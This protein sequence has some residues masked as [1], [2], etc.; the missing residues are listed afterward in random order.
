MKKDIATRDRWW[1]CSFI[2][3]WTFKYYKK[4]KWDSAEQTIISLGGFESLLWLSFFSLFDW[5]VSFFLRSTYGPLGGCG[6]LLIFFVGGT[7]G[8]RF[9]PWAQVVVVRQFFN[10]FTDSVTVFLLFVILCAGSRSFPPVPCDGQSFG[11]EAVLAL[12]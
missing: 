11:A 10:R 5:W 2:H 12:R 1:A 4:I 6:G 9:Y 3:F 7:P 8:N